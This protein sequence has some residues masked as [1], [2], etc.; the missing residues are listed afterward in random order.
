ME[1]TAD[2][3]DVARRFRLGGGRFGR[4]RYFCAR[5]LVALELED[6]DLMKR[7]LGQADDLKRDAVVSHAFAGEAEQVLIGDVLTRARGDDN[8]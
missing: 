5:R 7:N 1:Q 2:R 6:R 3:R 4:R 8:A